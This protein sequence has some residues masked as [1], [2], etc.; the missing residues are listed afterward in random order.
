MSVKSP[1]EAG[2]RLGT[3]Q[4][5]DATPATFRPRSVTGVASNNRLAKEQLGVIGIDLQPRLARAQG[6]L[7]FTK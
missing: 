2:E 3:T 6:T 4:S 7:G 5:Q 1:V